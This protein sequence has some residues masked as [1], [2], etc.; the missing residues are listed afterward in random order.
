MDIFGPNSYQNN[1]GK[2]EKL[3][4]KLPNSNDEKIKIFIQQ[5]KRDFQPNFAYFSTF[6]GEI[7]IILSFS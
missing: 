3:T 7:S 4:K 6:F 5:E 2:G 1:V